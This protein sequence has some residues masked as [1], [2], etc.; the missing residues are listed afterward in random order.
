[1]ALRLYWTIDALVLPL[2]VAPRHLRSLDHISAM[3]R[4]QG[5]NVFESAGRILFVNLILSGHRWQRPFV[6]V[7]VCLTALSSREGSSCPCLMSSHHH[8]SIHHSHPL[9]HLFKKPPVK[10]AFLYGLN[11]QNQHLVCYLFQKF[12]TGSGLCPM[13]S[14]SNDKAQDQRS[15][16][17]AAAAEALAT[18]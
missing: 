12:L 17:H 4:A 6:N 1:M 18:A 10:R 3:V 9:A 7:C 2:G 15:T 11:K 8:H 5:A 13:H 16:Q 14:S